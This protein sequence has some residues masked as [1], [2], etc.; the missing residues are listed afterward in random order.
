MIY[1]LTF[2]MLGVS[3]HALQ[4]TNILPSHL[5]NGLPTIEWAGIYPSWEVF[6]PQLIFV[7]LIALITVRQYGKD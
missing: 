4:L 1:A 2:K 6:L 3:I 7:A 5:F